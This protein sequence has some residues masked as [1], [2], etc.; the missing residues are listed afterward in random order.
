D[1]PGRI[2]EQES[3]AAGM[4]N[5]APCLEEAVDRNALL[6]VLAVVPA[7][8]IL[9]MCGVDVHRRQQHAFSRERHFICSSD[10]WL[11]TE[12]GLNVRAI[13]VA[14]LE[15]ERLRTHLGQRIDRAVYDIQLSRMPPVPCRNGEMHRRQPSPFRRR[16]GPRQSR[17]SP[18][19]PR[20]DLPHPIPVAPAEQ[21]WSPA[22]RPTKSAS[23]RRRVWPRE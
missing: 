1:R 16:M 23:Y 2:E 12:R 4:R 19:I 18:V 21:S 15:E 10:S 3:R 5:I 14:T 9:L 6:Q 7:V 8:E 13:E 17:H 20:K 11:S 22:R